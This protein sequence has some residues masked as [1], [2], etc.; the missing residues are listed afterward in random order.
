VKYKK[1]QINIKKER[2]ILSDVLPFEI[3]VSFSKRHFYS[4][5]A[6]NHISIDGKII[7][8]DKNDPILEIIIKLLFGFNKAK[9]VNN[10]QIK[11]DFKKGEGKT[12][13]FNYKISHKD[14]DFRELT[15]IH[16]KNQ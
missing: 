12:I 13:P 2:V 1:K 10:R 5:L 3:P 15:I 16:P 7:K 11:I 8:W 14:D 9:T 6:N 4:F